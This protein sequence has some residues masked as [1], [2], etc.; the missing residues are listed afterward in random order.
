MG[1]DRLLG[2][3]CGVQRSP[4]ASPAI[5]C[6]GRRRASVPP[7][8]RGSSPCTRRSPSLSSAQDR[9][10]DSPLTASP[11]GLG[12]SRS[13]HTPRACPQRS[14][15]PFARSVSPSP[16]MQSSAMVRDPEI[17]QIREGGVDL[18]LR[19]GMDPEPF[20][21]PCNRRETRSRPTIAFIARPWPDRTSALATNG[22]PGGSWC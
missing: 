1:R 7:G 18:C 6:S 12:G 15:M 17:R 14:S 4:A 19:T 8:H 16:P 21:E 13:A 2:I 5:R 22:N 20:S 11:I 3:A 9:A 10:A